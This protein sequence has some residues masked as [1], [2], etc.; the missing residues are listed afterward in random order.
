MEWNKRVKIQFNITTSACD[1]NRF[2]SREEFLDLRKDFDG[3]ELMVCGEDE[4]GII[5]PGDVV[6]LHMSCFYY[7]LD[8]WKGD[9]ERCRE[10]FGTLDTAYACY[11]GTDRQALIDRFRTDLAHAKKYGAEYMVFHI[12]DSSSLETLTGR[13]AHT[14]EEV[15]D[16]ACELINQAMDGVT[17][18]PMLLLENLWEPGLTLTRPEMT[19]RLL[20]GIRWPKKGIMLDTGHLLH[21]NLSLR[22]Q[23][24]GLEYIHRCLDAHGE[25]CRYI[26]GVHLN[27]SLTGSYMK[28]VRKQPPELSKDYGEKMGQL[29]EYV[30]QADQHKP[31]VCP[32][33][34]ELIDRIAPEYLTFEFIS[35]DLEQHKTMLRRQRRALEKERET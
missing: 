13:Y 32:G 22:T 5:Q 20:D 25:L 24:E 10:E 21:T 26:R 17:D 3:V 6:G 9:L 2:A 34:R 28:Q 19:R 1:L 15:I 23:K 18:D 33:V 27:Q 12:S 29:F 4:R 16:A 14:D 8:F 30:F 7:W 31:F 11:G 35:N